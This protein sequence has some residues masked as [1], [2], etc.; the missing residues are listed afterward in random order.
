M[1][2]P[3]RDAGGIAT[4]TEGAEAPF[5]QHLV[6]A[7][8]EKG[9]ASFDAVPASLWRLDAQELFGLL[10]W[11]SEHMGESD[12]R[13]YM[14]RSDLTVWQLVRPKPD[15]LPM[16]EDGSIAA[17]QE[18]MRRFV[19]KP[20]G[21]SI[22]VN[23]VIRHDHVAWSGVRDFV[24]G[25]VQLVGLPPGGINAGVGLG[26]YD[27]TP[28]GLHVDKGRSAF[29]LPIIGRKRFRIWPSRYVRQHPELARSRGE[30]GG[31]EKDSLVLEASPGGLMYWPSDAWHTAESVDGSFTA[32][33]AIGALLAPELE[34][35]PCDVDDLQGCAQ[36]VPESFLAAVA[37]IEGTDPS[38]DGT[39]VD[40]LWMSRLSGLGLRFPIPL[41]DDAPPQERLR[42]QR[43]YPIL[44][45][46]LSDGQ[47]AVGVNGHCVVES[48]DWLPELIERINSGVPFEVAELVSDSAGDLAAQKLIE[49][50]WT[51]RALEPDAETR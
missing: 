36:D 47:Y 41:R 15:V 7:Y 44:W 1:Y 16:K 8:W 4:A 34:T 28:F 21:Y 45:R 17:Y 43:Q 19:P 25:L 33:L 40:R 23:N 27:Y 3:E 24:R 29:V 9:S 18:R 20:D 39:A 14:T 13:Y 30:Y 6:D 37:A 32:M 31:L 51:C 5:W 38:Q 50:L 2:R 11:C 49:R 35:V 26:E 10:T 42:A 22:F 46:P 12:V 48:G